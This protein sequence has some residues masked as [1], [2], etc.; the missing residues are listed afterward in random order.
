LHLNKR[1]NGSPTPTGGFLQPSPDM[2]IL[3]SPLGT[4]TNLPQSYR[5]SQGHAG[6]DLTNL[7][8]HSYTL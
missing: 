1:K 8:T 6:S 4:S 7:L 3:F 5:F 2:A